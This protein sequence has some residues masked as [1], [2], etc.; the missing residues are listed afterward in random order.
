MTGDSLLSWLE[1]RPRAQTLLAV[2]MVAYFIVSSLIAART[3][4]PTVDEFVQLPMGYYYLKTG[5]FDMDRRNPPLMKSLSAVPL[6]LTDVKLDTDSQ[7]RKSGEGWWMWIFGTRFMRINQDRYFD[8][9]FWGRLVNVLLGAAAVTLIYLWARSWLG[10]LPALGTLLLASTT[11]P[12]LAHASL[13]TLDIGVTAFVFA[14]VFALYRLTIQPRWEWALAAG[15]L[16]GFALA[17]KFVALFFLP[18]IPLL[19]A[20]EWRPKDRKGVVRLAGFLVL[21][22]FSGWLAVN[23]AYF[24]KGFPLP[25]EMIDGIMLKTVERSHEKSLSYLLGMWSTQGWWYYYLV[26]FLYKNTVPFLLLLIAAVYGFARRPRSEWLRPLLWLALPAL[27]LFY[28]L[29]FHYRINFGIRYFLPALPFLLIIAGFGIRLLLQGGRTERVLLAGLLVWQVVACT[30]ATP[31]HLAYFN[32]AAYGPNR[33]RKIL[34]DSNL[35]WGQDL[36][37]LKTYMAQNGIDRIELG[38]YGSVD[39]KLYGINYALPPFEPKP[40]LYAVSANYLGGLPPVLLYLETD[41]FYAAEGYWSWLD[42]FEPV[43]R[44]GSSIYIFKIS[45][46]DLR[47]AKTAAN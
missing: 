23:A 13:A 9:F 2:L 30:A 46:E 38:Y 40:G 34:L 4:T 14:G 16:F 42:D 37:R 5:R 45:K 10:P 24:F 21:I 41:P 11:P 39:P 20:A 26:A 8:L 22:T 6:L 33:A 47:R 15:A 35:D 1:K 19:L 3:H 27:I 28:I 32:E 43:A 7:W 29:S 31:H 17:S 44:V 12:L 25:V 36:G 18:L